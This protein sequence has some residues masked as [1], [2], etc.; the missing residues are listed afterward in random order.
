MNYENSYNMQIES[1]YI[2]SLKNNNI[3]EKMTQRCAESCEKVGQKYKVF[4]GFD[5]N[6]GEIV[7]PDELKDQSWINWLRL[8]TSILT[9]T[10]IACLYSHFALWTKCIEIDRPIIIL[11]HDS[12][13]KKPLNYHP[14][15]NSIIY[16]G[17]QEQKNGAP[18]F[19]TPPHGS[20][21]KSKYRFICRAHAYSIDPAVAKN[22]IAYTIQQG[23][24]TTLDVMI[25]CDIFNISQ[26]GLYA[27]DDP[28]VSTIHKDWE[29]LNR[30]L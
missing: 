15:Y 24:H 3:S 9:P 6:S 13:V 25:N 5:G 23:I 12:I 14:L 4:Y 20:A 26:Y 7:V 21:E 18:I 22:L 27:Y 11:E 28:G 30:G 8:K 10:Q 29:Y 17:S 1:A 16:L 2:I 19:P